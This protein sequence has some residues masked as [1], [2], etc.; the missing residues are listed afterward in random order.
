MDSKNR[1][2]EKFQGIFSEYTEVR[3]R[4][5]TT[6]PADSLREVAGFLFNDL[7]A[8]FIIASGFDNGKE[9]EILYHFSFDSSGE[10]VSLRVLLDRNKPEVDSLVPLFRGAFWIEREIWELLGVNF[11]EHPRLEKFLFSDDWP[12]SSYPYQVSKDRTNRPPDA[13]PIQNKLF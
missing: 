12:E 7:A 2:Q 6:I 8:R 10:I 3:K 1:F 13:P 11:R 4:I 5:Y 9:I